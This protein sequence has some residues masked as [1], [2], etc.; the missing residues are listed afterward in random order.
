M[1]TRG[2]FLI[3]QTDAQGFS[4]Y[5]YRHTSD[6]APLETFRWNDVQAFELEKQVRIM[7]NTKAP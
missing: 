3:K 1:V 6:G 4:D 2:F 7:A 5:K